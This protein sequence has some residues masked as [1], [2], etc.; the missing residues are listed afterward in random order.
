[1]QQE[2]IA[3]SYGKDAIGAILPAGNF[4]KK[5]GVEPVDSNFG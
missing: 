3:V 4:I 1:V 2:K 5:F